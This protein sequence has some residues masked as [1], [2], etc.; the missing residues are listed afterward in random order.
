MAPSRV[1]LRAWLHYHFD[2]FYLHSCEM[3]GIPE[4]TYMIINTTSNLALS[5]RDTFGGV[6]YSDYPSAANFQIIYHSYF[7]EEAW[8]GDL[9]E[10]FFGCLFF[11]RF[12][13]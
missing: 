10:G 3:S 1:N 7:G 6:A 5:M 11:C 2:P 9:P 4:G 13:G 12:S 8:L